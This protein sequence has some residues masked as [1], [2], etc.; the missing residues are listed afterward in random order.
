MLLEFRV[1][2]F[3]SF[4]DQQVFSMIPDEGKQEFES[5]T[6]EVTDKYRILKS[7]IIYGANASGK[8]N[9]MKALQALRNLVLNS[10]NLEPDKAFEEYVPFQFNSRTA[11]APTVFELDFLIEAVRYNYH[12]SILKNQVVEEKLLFYPEGRESKLFVRKGMQFEFGDYL[13][14]Q[15]VVVSK[16]TGRNQLFLSKAARNNIAQL[17]EVYRFFAKDF[18]AVPFL[19]SWID[20]Y[21]VE[22]IAQELIKTKSNELF[23]KNFKNLLQSFDTGILDF[24]IEE[25]N[26]PIF[27]NEKY[28][29]TTQHAHFND[30]GQPAGSDFYP[31]EEESMGTQKL[32]VLGGLI[33]RALMNGRVIMID[34]FERSLHPLISSYLIQLFH[35]SKINTRGAQLIIAS[36][37]S[38]LLRSIE[39]RR[40]Q[41]WIVEKGKTGASELFSL[42]DLTGVLKGA[43]YE[44]WYLSGRLGGVPAVKSLDF[45]LKYAANEKK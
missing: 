10:A 32:F 43:P 33:L 7:A 6:L 14:G 29:I 11:S 23:I 18:M 5:N 35:D 21:Y 12:I 45:E 34:E 4:R 9:F 22:R 28:K 1:E 42:A 31:I 19:D 27:F 39:Y 2:N 40:D 37:D 8:S 20:S 41:I 13:K 25:A 17:E 24:N 36:H 26:A 44:K 16:L 38:N 3:R 30:A 15:K